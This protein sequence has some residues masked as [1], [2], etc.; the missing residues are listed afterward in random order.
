VDRKHFPLGC[1]SWVAHMKEEA[2][3]TAAWEADLPTIFYKTWQAEIPDLLLCC[4]AGRCL[5]A[6]VAPLPACPQT[7]VLCL[8]LCP[9]LSEVSPITFVLTCLSSIAMRT[10]RFWWELNGNKRN[11]MGTWWEQKDFDELL[12][13]TR[14][15][16]WELFAN[17]V[18][19]K[20]FWWDIDGNKRNLMGTWWE[21]KSPSLQKDK[22]H[23][24]GACLHHPIG[25]PLQK[26]RNIPRGMLVPNNASRW[27]GSREQEKNLWEYSMPCHEIFFIYLF[28]MWQISSDMAKYSMTCHHILCHITKIFFG[29]NQGL[30]TLNMG[31]ADIALKWSL[32]WGLEDKRK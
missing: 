31:L 8:A 20:G 11:L 6:T 3:Q 7:V 1:N 27:V 24:L 23:P 32:M 18:R 17:L 2:W 30:L 29:I 13:G 4:T 9:S 26:L 5:P 19:T 10:K 21:I 16:W 25:S 15:T 14:G 28:S 22:K 12:M